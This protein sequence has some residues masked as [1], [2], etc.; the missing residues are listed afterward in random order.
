MKLMRSAIGSKSASGIQRPTAAAPPEK[1][2]ALIERRPFDLGKPPPH[3]QRGD[4]KRSKSTPENPSPPSGYHW[5]K[6]HGLLTIGDY[7]RRYRAARHPRGD[8]LI[9]M[10]DDLL[11]CWQSLGPDWA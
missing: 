1:E 2:A 11:P 10:R 3:D 9:P 5:R 8:Y 6:A 7:M 4:M